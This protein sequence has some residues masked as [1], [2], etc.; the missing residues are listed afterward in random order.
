MYA[1]LDDLCLPTIDTVVPRMTTPILIVDSCGQ[2][3]A[4]KQPKRLIELK[5]CVMVV[6]EKQVFPGC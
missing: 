5:S 6:R 2:V 3:I 1:L 4:R